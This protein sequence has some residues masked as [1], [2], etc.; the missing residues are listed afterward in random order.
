MVV[1]VVVDVVGVIGR[2]LEFKFFSYFR[3]ES[4]LVGGSYLII[5]LIV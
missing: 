2:R 4:I 1:I 5:M 3:E